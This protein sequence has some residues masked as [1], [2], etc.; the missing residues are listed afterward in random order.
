VLEWRGR[1][2]SSLAAPALL[3]VAYGRQVKTS[4][5][6]MSDTFQFLYPRDGSF[7]DQCIYCVVNEPTVT[8]PPG[9]HPICETVTSTEY[10]VSPASV[11]TAIVSFA[12][13][14]VFIG[15]EPSEMLVPFCNPRKATCSPGNALLNTSDP[16]VVGIPV[17]PGIGLTRAGCTGML[18]GHAD[19]ALLAHP[20]NTR[21][22]TT[23]NACEDLMN[24]YPSGKNFFW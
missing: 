6:K 9:E 18:W 23:K 17:A 22:A 20:F 13:A 8:A 16:M 19:P 10:V 21:I 3:F 14:L 2:I 12:E 7:V 24:M 1:Q 15:I 11:G 4:G 5:K